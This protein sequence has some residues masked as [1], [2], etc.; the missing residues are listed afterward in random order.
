MPQLKSLNLYHNKMTT[1]HAA[2]FKYLTSLK[3]LSLSNNK[4]KEIEYGAWEDL[5]RLES[6]GLSS[7]QI[8]VVNANI[9]Y[10]L[11]SL[12]HLYLSSNNITVIETEAFQFCD[13]LSSLH[14]KGNRFEFNSN[15][16][17]FVL[18]SLGDTLTVLS[19]KIDPGEI[20][21]RR[22]SENLIHLRELEFNGLNSAESGVFKNFDLLEKLAL[23][24]SELNESTFKAMDSKV[25][26]DVS[27]TLKRLDLRFNRITSL[28]EDMFINPWSSVRT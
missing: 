7:N 17:Q 25:F 20:L 9:F 14:L 21:T 27:D 28:Y 12:I 6:L 24:Y 4:I 26:I 18:S 10:N 8:T 19:L 23:S 22:A 15:T 5:E 3:Y 1:L 2:V 16:L 11:T 13:S